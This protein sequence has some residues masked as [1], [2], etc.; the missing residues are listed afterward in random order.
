M[1]NTSMLEVRAVVDSRL[2]DLH[3][4][5]IKT[6]LGIRTHFRDLNDRIQ[7]NLMSGLPYEEMRGINAA[8]SYA[9]QNDGNLGIK[10]G[11]K[12]IMEE[13]GIGYK[14]EFMRAGKKLREGRARNIGEGIMN[15]PVFMQL[16]GEINRIPQYSIDREEK[17]AAL[18]EEFGIP[19]EG[20]KIL[21]R[22][23]DTF[24]SMASSTARHLAAVK[25]EG[26][27]GYLLW[28]ALT[29]AFIF[30]P[31]LYQMVEQ[32]GIKLT[33]AAIGISA[34]G[35]IARLGINKRLLDRDK[36]NMDLL[37]TSISLGSRLRS[38]V[39]LTQGQLSRINTVAAVIGASFHTAVQLSAH[40]FPLAALGPESALAAWI[41]NAWGEVLYTG[42]AFNQLRSNQ[43]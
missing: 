8:V 13:M 37:E 35:L 7:V 16:A 5:I 28:A 17:I 26:S 18:S 21:T 19:V 33:A 31:Q 39:P 10:A 9:R 2:N 23:P 34:V 36:N 38:E 29:P 24:S 41:S 43:S 42:I 22:A 12:G 27:S 15:A 40:T 3:Q 30:Q 6:E 14:L 11:F 20:S 1:Y 25:L 4:S 32:D